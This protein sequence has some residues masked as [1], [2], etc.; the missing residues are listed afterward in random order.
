[1]GLTLWLNHALTRTRHERRGF[2][3]C[4]CPPPPRRPFGLPVEG[5]DAPLHSRAGAL[6]LGRSVFPSAL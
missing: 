3:R 5:Y 2:N 1:M 6:G 4:V